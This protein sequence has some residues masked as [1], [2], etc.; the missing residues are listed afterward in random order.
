MN[1]SARG[2]LWQWRPAVL[3][4]AAA[5][6]SCGGG[7][8]RPDP[9][10]FAKDWRKYEVVNFTVYAPADS[11]RPRRGIEAFGK[12]CDET[13]DY[14]AKQLKLKIDDD[15]GIYLFT[16]TEDCEAA[17]G[18]PASFV[19]GLNIYTRLGA[20]IG[21][22]VA[23]AMCNTIDREAASFPLIRDGIRNLFDERDR[24]IHYEALGLRQSRDWPT[25]EDLLYRQAASD[26]DVYKYA[27][28][29][30]VA[31][32]IQRYGTDQFKM[33]WRSALELRPSIEKIYG[34]TLPQMEEEW[35]RIQ[36]KLAKRT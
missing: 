36:D 10:T 32:L 23:E 2:T 5:A 22:L 35:F 21:G 9:Q 1:M 27:S 7:D 4:L 3:L 11:P 18:R 24:N 6:F 15:I 25:L 17:T 31:F 8:K 33:L 14:I 34:G 28:A 19:D 29:S 30:F 16:T 26:P 12:A 13:Y 20:P